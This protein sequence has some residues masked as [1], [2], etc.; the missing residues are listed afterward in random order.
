MPTFKVSATY[1][2][3]YRAT[4]VTTVTGFE[5]VQKGRSF[6]DSLI[7]R[8]R[9][10]FTE[11]NLG[12][13]R[14]TAVHLIGAQTLWGDNAD[15]SAPQAREIVTRIDVR[16]D[17]RE[18]LDL[19]SKETT[20]VGLSM[21]TGR[22]S[23]GATGRPKITPVV[24]QFAFLIDKNKVQQIVRV[25]G[26][27]IDFT[28]PPPSSFSAQTAVDAGTDQNDKKTEISDPVEVPLIKIAV[29]RSGDKG[30]NA[31]IG[32]LARA[33]ELLEWI[34]AGVTAEKVRHW[35]QHTVEGEV[36]RFDLPGMHA[37]N[38]VLTQCLGGGGTSSLHLDTQAKTYGQQL[39]AMPVAVPKSIAEKIA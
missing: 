14:G 37:L 8:T 22:C 11:R 4:A 23:A 26:Q 36:E 33:P 29:A 2:D 25:D 20:G 21:T 24:A 30:N 27:M 34:R 35:F 3:G 39:L 6:A 38:F 10:L 13:Y 31:N 15:E 9:R 5:A 32:V 7:K 17:Q 12:D 16:H 28:A 18:A 1:R 19:F